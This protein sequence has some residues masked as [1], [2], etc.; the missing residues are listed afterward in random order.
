MFPHWETN[1]ILSL[2]SYYKVWL[3]SKSAHV[4]N[5]LSMFLPF[6]HAFYSILRI[7]TTLPPQ[8]SH[9]SFPISPTNFLFY[10]KN[11]LIN[12]LYFSHK[13]QTYMLGL[14]K[15]GDNLFLGNFPDFTPVPC[16]APFTFHCSR[17]VFFPDLSSSVN[18]CFVPYISLGIHNLRRERQMD[19]P[20]IA[21]SILWLSAG[22]FYWKIH[23]HRNY[24]YSICHCTC[25]AYH[26][27]LTKFL[28]S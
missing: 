26:S 28:L 16:L 6:N 3:F 2:G 15:L 8:V 11:L 12:S 14:R 18:H 7:S 13:I 17:L 5:F 25:S 24:V 9:R 27:M 20:H 21:I 4:D 22:P 19:G 1:S 10:N 23:E